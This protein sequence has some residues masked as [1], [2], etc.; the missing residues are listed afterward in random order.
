MQS[1]AFSLDRYLERVAYAGSTSPS[2]NLL[3]ALQ[4]A[5]LATIPF[6]NFDILLGRGISVEPQHIA[7]KLLNSRRGGYCFELNGLFLMAVQALGFDAR[8]LL[9]RVHLSG[10]PSGRSHELLLV[11]IEGRDWIADAGFGGPSLRAP[12]PLE[13]DVERRQDGRTFRLIDAG[14]FG[15]MLQMLRDGQ[16]ADLYSFDRGQV[17]PVDIAV[18]NHFTS[19][20]PRSHFTFTR[21]AALHTPDGRTTLLDTTLRRLVGDTEQTEELEEGPRYI[22]ALA[23]Q[24]GIELDAG[25]AA[26]RPLRPRVPSG[27]E[28]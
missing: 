5:Q 23:Q 24:F 11:T 10:Q 7:Q 4:R 15:T 20:H 28:G 25:Y 8:P 16:W 3:E 27:R 13:L 21:I 9:A 12:I 6:E 14:P 26:L 17:L 1:Q 22:E 2:E 18:G 19:T